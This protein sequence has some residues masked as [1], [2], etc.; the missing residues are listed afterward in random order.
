MKEEGLV[1]RIKRRGNYSSYAG[2]ITP[3]AGNILERDFH[4]DKPNQKWLTDITE[5]AIP[6]GK[7]YLSPIVD[8]FDGLPVTWNISTKP[9]ATLVN[10]MLDHAIA[11]LHRNEHPILHSDRGCHYRWDEWIEKMEDAGLIR[12]MSKKRMFARQFSL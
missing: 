5:F 8:C 12:S 7:I 9:N 1:V 4:T 6:A 11:T 2:E 10:T 3:E